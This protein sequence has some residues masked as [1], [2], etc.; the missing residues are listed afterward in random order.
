MVNTGYKTYVDEYGEIRL[1]LIIRK[2]CNIDT[3]DYIEI[4]TNENKIML[5]KCIQKCIICDNMGNLEI[6]K[7]K[8]ICSMCMNNLKSNTNFEE[9]I[10]SVSTR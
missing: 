6:F 4:F 5:K 1:P 7:G 9:T 8:C 2:E 10:N 3:N